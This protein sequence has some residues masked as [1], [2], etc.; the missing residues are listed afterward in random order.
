[1]TDYNTQLMRGFNAADTDELRAWGE[2]QNVVVA[3]GL[4]RLAVTNACYRTRVRIAEAMAASDD[5]TGEE[6]DVFVSAIVEAPAHIDL[7]N[8]RMAPI[9]WLAIG[10]AAVAALRGKS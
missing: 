8:G 3:P 1:M 5:V 2:R 6:R 9:D 10:R 4:D 7:G